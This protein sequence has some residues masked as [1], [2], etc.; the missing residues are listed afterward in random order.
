MSSFQKII[1][2][3]ESLWWSDE[4]VTMYLESV[5]QIDLLA[6]FNQLLAI[7]EIHLAYQDSLSSRHNS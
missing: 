4:L 5:T 3:P 2:F 7:T 1:D 6:N